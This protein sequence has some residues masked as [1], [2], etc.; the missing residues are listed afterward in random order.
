MAFHLNS[1]PLSRAGLAPSEVAVTGRGVGVELRDN[2]KIRRA[3]SLV[4][5][6]FAGVIILPE[7]GQLF[8]LEAPPGESGG[9][10]G[11]SRF[12]TSSSVAN[13]PTSRL[14]LISLSET[15]PV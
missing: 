12:A 1:A 14:N 5:W 15:F 6:A 11:V 4:E 10:G 3:L 13:S 8:L 9:A 7:G 2:R